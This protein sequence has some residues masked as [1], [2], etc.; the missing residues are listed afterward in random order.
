MLNGVRNKENQSY[1]VL[2]SPSKIFDFTDAPLTTERRKHE[3]SERK[4]QYE[5]NTVRT[6]NPSLEK[7]HS[8]ELK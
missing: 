5:S 3:A 6:V 2:C 7:C 4:R 1:K 8:P